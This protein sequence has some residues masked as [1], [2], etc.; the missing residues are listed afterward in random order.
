VYQVVVFPPPDA[1]GALDQFRRLHDPAFHRGPAY[2]PLT[3]PFDPT[4]GALLARFDTFHGPRRFE[5]TLGPAEARGNAL[6]LP[7][8]RGGAQLG[9]LAGAL[10]DD[11]LREGQEAQPTNPA[12]R[13]G[14]FGSEAELELARRAL[15]TTPATE[16]FRVREVALLME[17]ERGLWHAVRTRRLPSR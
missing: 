9:R 14:F 4:D 11:L 6:V 8:R 1:L 12:L 2:L 5:V 3:P 17:D 13:I 7:P 10:A 16:P 15:G